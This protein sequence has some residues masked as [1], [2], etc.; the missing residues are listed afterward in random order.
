MR[1]LILHAAVGTGHTT[2]ALALGDAFRRTQVDEVQVEDILDYGSRF[3]RAALTQSYLLVSGRTPQLWKVFYESSDL[4]DPDYVVAVNAFLARVERLP[5]RRLEQ[6]VT[7]YAPDI[8]VCTH[9]LPMAV[10]GRLKRAGTL[11]QPL[12]CVVTDFMVHSLW[13]DDIVDGYFVASE[14]TRDAMIA[15][16]VRPTL[17]HVTGIPV[18]PEIA[19]PKAADAMRARHGLPTERPTIVLFG[20]GIEPQ[21]VRLI[22]ER[23]LESTTPGVLVVVAG[24]SEALTKSLAELADGPSMQLRRLGRIN[25]VDDLVA[26][27]DLVITKS[28]GL[29]VSEVLARGTP[30]IVLD[31][32]PGQEEW[33]ADYVAGSGAGIQLR[34]PESV[35][36]AALYLLAQPQ[37]LA[38][39]RG[40]AARV[41]RPRAA[42]DVADYVLSRAAGR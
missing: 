39:M 24:R 34:Y 22:V 26:A 4:H 3:F 15:R 27:A 9:M 10:I 11:R 25:Y 5:V 31:P 14:L 17:L 36:P 13:I 21:R 1:I 35:P 18:N 20:G 19:D 6:F 7:S 2:A 28:G 32:I 42:L 8:I 33:N 37:R 41:G 30:M 12:Y 23:L 38:A 29:I 16:G 40:Q